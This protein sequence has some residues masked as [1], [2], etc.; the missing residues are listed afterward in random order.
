M[1]QL[2]IIGIVF[3]LGVFMVVVCV[4]LSSPKC[5]SKVCLVGK[6]ALVTG[7]SSGIGYQTVLGLAARGCRVIVADQNVDEKIQR[8]LIKESNN[9]NIIMQYVDLASF[10]SV[11]EL[12]RRLTASEDK[13]DILINNAGIGK[14]PDKLSKDDLDDTWQIN[15]FSAFLL[16]HLLIGLLKKS[17][18][19][20]VIFTSSLLSHVHQLS[21]ENITATEIKSS[22]Y[23]LSYSD[24]KVALI[25][26]SDIFATKLNK[27]NITS[28]VYHPGIANTA[29][30]ERS[31]RNMEGIGEK[32]LV[33]VLR[34]LL[35]FL[36]KT[37]EDGAQT[38]LH[39]AVS[40]E[41]ENITGRYF[42]RLSETWKPRICKDKILCEKIW[43][44]S[45][46]IVKLESNERL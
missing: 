7:G 15:Y 20:R 29:I 38:A 1:I 40:R 5:T 2:L 10:E 30:F 27:F 23:F 19:G 36:N 44:T 8:S 34:L 11:R 21:S 22:E 25:I 12:A 32:A 3:L 37:P 26:A 14:G 9:P 4:I 31:M 17:S 16:T 39:L 45:E 13:L 42:G 18:A 46:T 24:T 33:F 43:T 6:T 35:F 41:V 28:N